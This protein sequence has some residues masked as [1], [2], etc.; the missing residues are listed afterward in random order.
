M[1]QDKNV[2]PEIPASLEEAATKT[3]LEL[4]LEGLRLYAAT[5]LGIDADEIVM[6]AVCSVGV[7]SEI[8]V[9]ARHKR[10]LAGGHDWLAIVPI[11]T[12]WKS[13]THERM[14]FSDPS[15]MFPK[16]LKLVEQAV[17]LDMFDKKLE[18][19]VKRKRVKTFALAT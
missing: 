11:T 3:S 18:L 5:I 2:T 17:D 9:R 15:E 10:V 6:E 13:E 19:L 16:Y 12:L 7:G 8:V 4:V 1:D 14:E